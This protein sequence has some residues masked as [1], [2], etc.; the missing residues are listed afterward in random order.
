[1]AEGQGSKI[2][3]L[4]REAW[5]ELGVTNQENPQ[6][7]LSEKRL[8]PPKLSPVAQAKLNDRVLG[9]RHKHRA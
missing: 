7:P 2:H 8:P 5:A 4:T 3:G 1:M 6:L 9:V